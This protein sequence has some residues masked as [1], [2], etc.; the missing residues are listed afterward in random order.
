MKPASGS[1]DVCHYLPVFKIMLTM[2]CL[3]SPSQAKINYYCQTGYYGHMETAAT[4][5]L[6]R[7][8]NDPVLKFFVAFA[9]IL[10]SKLNMCNAFQNLTIR[11]CQ[12]LYTCLF[13]CLCTSDELFM[14][15]SF[16]DV[17][18]M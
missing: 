7:Y 11:Q 3:F 4:E 13:V 16:V 10:Q 6:Q 18:I 1:T 15:Q 8:G 14:S 2:Q 17:I 5:G 9:K 12:P